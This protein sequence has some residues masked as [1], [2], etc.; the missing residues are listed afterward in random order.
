MISFNNMTVRA[1]LLLVLAFPVIGLLFFSVNSVLD[2]SR[3]ANAMQ[4]L[5]A[6]AELSVRFSAVAHELQIERGMTGGFL[7]SRGERFASE[8]PAQRTQSDRML[9]EL[10]TT[11]QAFDR[12]GQSADLIQALNAAERDLR[13]LDSTRGAI[14]NHS[15][16]GA[17]ALGYYT[18]TIASLLS[19][20][21]QAM[22]LSDD[23]EVTRLA[24]AYSNLS[25]AK[26]R[27]GIERAVLN[28]VFGAGSFTP[29]MVERFLS[30]AAA[31]ATYFHEFEV[32]AGEQQMQF[33]RQTVSGREV[34]ASERMVRTAVEGI[35]G[36]PLNV[37]ADHWFEMVTGRIDRLKDV[38]DRL[39]VD[40]M[41]AAAA[42]RAGAQ[43]TL[44]LFLLLTAMALAAT[45]LLAFSTIRSIL[46][47]LGGEPALAASIAGRIAA[48]EL[49]VQVP[50]RSGDSTS[51]MAAMRTMVEKLAGIVTE[52][53]QASDAVGTSAQEIATGNDDLSQ[54]T[55]EQA[56]ALEETASSMEEMTSTVKQNADSASQ[57]N[58]LAIGA[59]GQAET[60]GK[61]VSQA[62]SAMN[63]ISASSRKIADII[64]VIDEIAFQTNLLAL[65]AAVEAARAGE[66][67]RGFAVVATEVRN[68]AQ[69]SAGAA[70]EIKDLI[71]DSV[72]KVKNGS[73]LVDNSGKTLTE[74]VESV[75]KV[76]D[77][78]AEIAAASQEQS[79][80]IEQ[81]N[82]AI[83]QMDEVTQQNASL[84]EEA[85]AASRSMEEQAQRMVEIMSFFRTAGAGAQAHTVQGG[86]RENPV[87]EDSMVAAHAG[88]S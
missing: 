2:R 25:H 32:A 45:A 51:L 73:E 62:V 22:L 35:D 26:E 55:Q 78:V 60:G 76:T 17:D 34:E 77:I 71:K 70:K 41:D 87:S 59:R 39:A 8:L 12:S 75:K 6:L 80:G 85:A 3:T 16:A 27:A 33:F 28:V 86:K 9:G 53:R 50:V 36:R 79:A 20:G 37:D 29:E 38:E 61:V 11:L 5:E 21:R 69:R 49:D 52:V 31:Q 64:S 72:E 13:E 65:N 4:D 83:T 15:I 54:R 40:L 82:K 48:G 19:V 7:A 1:R 57:A 18:R 74:I 46:R 88:A 44:Y 10:N 81:V 84:V 56:S 14:S 63:E 24:T 23:R 43:N 47:Q 66:Q 58:Q 30:N 68:L 67:G 42:L